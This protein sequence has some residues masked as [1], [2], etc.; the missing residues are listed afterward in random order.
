M[1]YVLASWARSVLFHRTAGIPC[2]VRAFQLSAQELEG[3]G[4]A[5][6]GC[7]GGAAPLNG[8]RNIL[9]SDILVTVTDSP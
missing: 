7:K 5:C 9:N 3:R 8:D 6:K 2:C 1:K 4:A